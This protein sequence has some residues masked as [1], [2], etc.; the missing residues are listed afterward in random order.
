[1]VYR[2]AAPGFVHVVLAWGGRAALLCGRSSVD[3]R[4]PDG[5]PTNPTAKARA[6]AS[7]A[8]AVASPVRAK[9]PPTRSARG[10]SRRVPETQGRGGCGDLLF[11]A[12]FSSLRSKRA[13]GETPWISW[14]RLP[15][16]GVP[17]LPRS[18]ICLAQILVKGLLY[19][20]EPNEVTPGRA[21]PLKGLSC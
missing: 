3:G 1:M 13:R 17:P 7:P 9:T 10:E 18:R 16:L 8:V 5:N 2:F 14:F 21:R 12:G 6:P 15:G 19:R 20:G 11:S 4:S